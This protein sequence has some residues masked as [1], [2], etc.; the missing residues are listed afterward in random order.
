MHYSLRTRSTW[1]SSGCSI[2]WE[3]AG[4]AAYT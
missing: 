2:G 3:P 1:V 4:W